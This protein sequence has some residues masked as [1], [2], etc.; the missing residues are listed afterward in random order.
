MLVSNIAQQRIIRRRQ[1]TGG[2]DRACHKSW[3]FRRAITVGNAPC[4]TCCS[5]VNLVRQRPQSILVKLESTCSEGVGFDNVRARFKKTRVNLFD[6][7]WLCQH[8]V[9]V[10][11]FGGLTSIIFRAQLVALYIRPHCAIVNDDTLRQGIQKLTH[12][13]TSSNNPLI[14]FVYVLSAN[15]STNS[16]QKAGIS[17]TTRPHTIFPSRNA[18]SL[19]Q[20]PPALVIS[21]LMPVEPVALCPFIIPAEMGTHPP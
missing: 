7:P 1:H 3:L 8:K 15:A 13:M 17:S 19:T 5:Q 2:A 18:A 9:F 16:R 11:P 14:P 10:A 6:H 12:Q 4:K 20:V 21:S